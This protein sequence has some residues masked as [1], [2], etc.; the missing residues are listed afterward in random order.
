MLGSSAEGG[1]KAKCEHLLFSMAEVKHARRG[2][3][4]KFDGLGNGNKKVDRSQQETRGAL[5]Q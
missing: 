5:K 4:S 3:L 1:E 2:N